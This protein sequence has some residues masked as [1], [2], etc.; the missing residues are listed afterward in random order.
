M[1]FENQ[2]KKS[3]YVVIA[4]AIVSVIVL[5]SILLTMLALTT[6]GTD[7]NPNSQIDISESI[8]TETTTT[9]SSSS[10]S[11]TETTTT[12]SMT[13]TSVTTS[14]STSVSSKSTSTE[15]ST[16]KKTEETVKNTQPVTEAPIINEPVATQSVQPVV[17]PPVE[18]TTK[19]SSDTEA[20]TETSETTT[21]T[22]IETE[23][24]TTDSSI[25]DVKSNE[26]LAQEV[27]HGLWGNGADR[28]KRL[29]DAGYDYNAVQKIV[30]E[31]M[32]SAIPETTPIGDVNAT[33]VKNFSRG[34]Y[35]AYGGPRKGGSGRQ[36]ID[37]SQGDGNVK[38]SIASSYL[39][40]N[41]GYNYNGKR[42]MVYLEIS[43]YPYMTGYY[44]L[45]DSDAG[46]PNVIDF[47]YLYNSN[48]QFQYQGVVS[49]DCYIVTY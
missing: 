39:Y 10:T 13:S 38:G 41:Y 26:E 42:T 12:T 9:T 47:F 33:Y 21:E 6:N 31:L 14:T 19:E 25:V 22:I 24:P 34:T 18:T 29:T 27:I 20:T 32:K 8:T 46:N 37:C 23:P 15:T 5:V 3:K 36:L 30:D 17:V 4:A 49:V 44:Y 43:G 35:Y 45:D 40:R 11:T 16:T 2:S 28:V 48:C 1:N 7:G